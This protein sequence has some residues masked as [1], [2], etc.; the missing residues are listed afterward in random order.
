MTPRIKKNT[1]ASSPE[2]KRKQ[3][4]RNKLY[5]LSEQRKFRD[6]HEL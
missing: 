6:E 4:V 1:D 2:S 5:E 3:V